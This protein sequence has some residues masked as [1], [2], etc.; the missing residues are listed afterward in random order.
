MPCSGKDLAGLTLTERMH[1]QAAYTFR[2]RDRSAGAGP[3]ALGPPFFATGAGPAKGADRGLARVWIPPLDTHRDLGIGSRMWDIEVQARPGYV[4]P[5][6][7]VQPL[8]ILLAG[9]L[10][11]GALF[12]LVRTLSTSGRQ[13]QE[14]A[15][16][17]SERL[18]DRESQLNAIS[19]VIPDLLFMLDEEGA[20]LSIFTADDK[21]LIAPRATL[22]N[23]KVADLLPPPVAVEVLAT[24]TAALVTG[25]VQNYEYNMELPELG[26]RWF[27]ARVA[28][29]ERPVGGKGC[30][31][32]VSR[33]VTERTLTEE[34][35]RQ[36]QKLE[37]MGLL[38]GG[39]AHDFNNLLTA[40]LGNLNLAQM[41]LVPG[42]RSGPFLEQAEKSVMK[43][44]ALTR[45]M[46]AYSGKA[47]LVVAPLDLNALVE[48]MTS[49]LQVSIAKKITLRL[50][51]CPDLPMV[52]GDAAQLQQV[53]MNLI[54]NAS[55]AI[56]E[57]PGRI[58]VCT[59]VIEL[60]GD[61]IQTV[62]PGTTL[63]SGS[64]VTLEVNDDGCGMPPEVLARIFDPFYTTK[65]TGRGLGLSAML[66]IVKEHKGAIKIYSEVSVGS[67]FKLFFPAC[68][69]APRAIPMP[70][71]EATG[72]WSGTVL[73]VDDE[74]AVR[75]ATGMALENLGLTVL[76]AEDGQA[77]LELFTADP[78]AIDL[79][80]M[81]LTMPR[82]NGHECFRLLRA[83]RPD[84]GIIL[85]SGYNALNLDLEA[86]D[87][88]AGFLQKPYTLRSL[89]S[90]VRACLPNRT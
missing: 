75:E 74:E 19:R 32:W 14:L 30:V 67:T 1:Q 28:K 38:A 86:L 15:L 69:V 77:A 16:Y 8:I 12:A 11:S 27:E 42:S 22:M 63:A 65:L 49:L 47:T 87:G 39:I 68:R 83:Q 2:E 57:A 71:A 21:L 31:V 29:M 72:P 53:V 58:L 33:D 45:Q 79:V 56:G 54:T 76:M 48:E 6:E 64:Y 13:A 55:E 70:E 17:A 25:E 59:T 43:A 85:C 10:F 51:L 41:Y 78:G 88:L 5:Q 18:S 7:Q 40:I 46:L 4:T 73:L 89:R 61:S 24:I 44:S 60:E 23:S 82:M 80:V 35:Q 81:D 3:K 90:L 84:L 26:H 50:E 66:G 62:T 37:S 36:S 20:Y 52:E 34:H 9:F